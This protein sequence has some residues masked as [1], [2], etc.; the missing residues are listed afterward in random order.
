MES[1]IKNS[2]LPSGMAFAP[3]CRQGRVGVKFTLNFMRLDPML[4][5]SPVQCCAGQ[6]QRL[7]GLRNIAFVLLKGFNDK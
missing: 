6:P 3:A 7:G 5:H 1:L 4:F 2:C